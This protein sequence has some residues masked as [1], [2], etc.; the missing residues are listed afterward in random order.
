MTGRPGPG[1]AITVRDATPADIPIIQG[2]YA[3]HVL[4]GLA[5]FEEVPPDAAEME[6]RYRDILGRG[7]P[8]VVAAI[9]GRVAAYAYAGPYRARPA[10]RST[11]EDSV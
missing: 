11:L 2:I 7:L 10:Y 8:Y 3:H 6:R 9:D 4:H 1:P 5:S